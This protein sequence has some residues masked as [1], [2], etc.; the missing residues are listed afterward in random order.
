MKFLQE[1]KK[2][3]R[4]AL[5]W[6]SALSWELKEEVFQEEAQLWSPI[7][8]VIREDDHRGR[9]WVSM[10]TGTFQKVIEVEV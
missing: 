1:T 6:E 2:G 10:I 9:W 3:R 5:G 8:R 4:P 7:S